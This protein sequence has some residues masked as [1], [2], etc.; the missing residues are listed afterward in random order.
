MNTEMDKT[1]NDVLFAKSVTIRLLR[2]QLP[3]TL[4]TKH[5][6]GEE[7]QSQL[8]A[9]LRRK[10]G[11]NC[12]RLYCGQ[13][14]NIQYIRPVCFVVTGG[15][16]FRYP[17]DTGATEL[18]FWASLV[19]LGTKIIIHQSVNDKVCVAEHFFFHREYN[20]R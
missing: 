15:R 5:P 20:E 14:Y 17:K 9:F 4:D 19:H 10:L 8:A 18:Q 2:L 7:D 13:A 3:G 1:K 6:T 16:V 11:M 12:A